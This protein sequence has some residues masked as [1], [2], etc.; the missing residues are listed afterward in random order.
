MSCFGGS[1]LLL[2]ELVDLL[3]EG[4]QRLLSLELLVLDFGLGCCAPEV[5]LV[6]VQILFSRLTNGTTEDVCVLLLWEVGIIV[7]VGVRELNW[8]ITIVFPSGVGSH[9]VWA[10]ITPLSNGQITYRLALVVISDNHGSLVSLVI[11]NLSPEEPLSS[12]SHLLEDVVWAHFHNRD[13]LVQTGFLAVL[14]GASLVLLDFSAA[15]SGNSSWLQDHK[16]GILHVRVA[17]TTVLVT[18]CF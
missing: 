12:L 4:G 13:L 3:G 17:L 8:V 6:L 16:L 2:V 18:E 11:N 5:V 15:T 7:S 9:V 10:T 1:L 14:G